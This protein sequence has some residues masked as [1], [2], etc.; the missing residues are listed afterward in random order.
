MNEEQYK[1]WRH[2]AIDSLHVK[3]SLRECVQIVRWFDD[4]DTRKE[5]N[6]VGEGVVESLLNIFGKHFN[7]Y[8]SLMI[9]AWVYAP[10][11]LKEK[12]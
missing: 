9:R 12:N 11:I 1:K 6:L 5:I 4:I 10:Y 8:D 3:Y 7:L 2:D